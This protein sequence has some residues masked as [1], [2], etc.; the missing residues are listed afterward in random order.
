MGVKVREK[1]AN[2]GTWWIFINHQGKR[3]AKKVGRDKKLALDAAKKIEAKLAL[4]DVGLLQEEQKVP[5]VR[6]ICPDVDQRHGAGH[7]QTIDAERLS[8]DSGQARSA[9]VQKSFS[10]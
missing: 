4:G 2:S 7:L 6:R 10:E 9:G 8:D 5:N 3:R 1:P